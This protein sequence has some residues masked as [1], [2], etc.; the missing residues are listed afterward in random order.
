MSNPFV[1]NRAEYR[2]LLCLCLT[3]MGIPDEM[4]GQVLERGYPQ[5]VANTLAECH[6]RGVAAEIADVLKYAA[7]P[8]HNVAYIGGQ[9][10]FYPNDVD[11]LVDQLAAAGKLTEV[12]QARS[13]GGMTAEEQVDVSA[14]KVAQ[15]LQRRAVDACR[16]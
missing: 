14:E 6:W 9:P 7:D 11:C 16:N 4:H 15:E 12:A 1:L 2:R 10:A 5:D 13:Q 8:G 3:N